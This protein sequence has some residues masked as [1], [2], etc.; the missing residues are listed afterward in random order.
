MDNHPINPMSRGVIPVAIL[1]LPD[2]EGLY[3]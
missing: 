1:G 3:K 2:N